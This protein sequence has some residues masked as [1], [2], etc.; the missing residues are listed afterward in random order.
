MRDFLRLGGRLIDTAIVYGNQRQI[1]EVL[2][3]AEFE[4]LRREE[5]FITS[6]IPSMDFGEKETKA[7]MS[8][9]LKELHTEYVDLV[10]LHAP[11]ERSQNIAAWLVLERELADGR[12]KAIGVS[13]FEVSHLEQLIEDGAKVLPMNNQISVHPGNPQ[14]DTLRYCKE[15][16]ISITAYNSIKGRGSAIGGEATLKAIAAAHNR[17]EAQVLLRWGVE[18]GISVIPGCTSR[19]HIEE[20]LDVMRFG[21]LT[22]AEL[23]AL[24]RTV[25]MHPGQD[26][27]KH[28]L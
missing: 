9:I 4:L 26:D 15:H 22:A 5:L 11:G 17:T 2:H 28:E 16:G 19:E 23:A 10:L 8:R 1:S 6:K 24:G 25:V 20:A 3:E 18:H 27:E 21:P 12:A 7:A 14:L 13:N